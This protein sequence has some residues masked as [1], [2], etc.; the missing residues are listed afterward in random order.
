[1]LANSNKKDYQQLI[2]DNVLLFLNLASTVFSFWLAPLKLHTISKCAEFKQLN[3]SL[4]LGQN[5]IGSF[6][7]LHSGSVIVAQCVCVIL[8]KLF[9]VGRELSNLRVFC[10]LQGWNDFQSVFDVLNDRVS[11]S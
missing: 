5:V 11:E 2:A 10:P 6:C 8:H 7:N 4:H 3:I 9:H 1:M